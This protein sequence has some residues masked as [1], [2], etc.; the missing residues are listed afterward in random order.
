MDPAAG[1]GATFDGLLTVAGCALA[2]IDVTI[3][4]ATTRLMP[5]AF[6]FIEN[7]GVIDSA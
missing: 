7:L 3:I 1:L 4:A 6:T 2:A 5:A